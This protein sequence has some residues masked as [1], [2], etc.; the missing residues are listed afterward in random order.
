[1]EVDARD[2][3]FYRCPDLEVLLIMLRDKVLE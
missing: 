2:P 3:L 1:M